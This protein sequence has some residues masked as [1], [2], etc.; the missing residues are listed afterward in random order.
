MGLDDMESA[1]YNLAGLAGQRQFAVAMGLRQDFLAEGMGY[2]WLGCVLPA[3][4]GTWSAD[5]VRHGNT[6]YNEQ[7][8]SVAYALPLS[9]Q[10]SLGAALHYLYSGTSDPYYTPQHLLTFSLAT[11]YRPN[12]RLT[13]GVR[14][15]NPVSM[16]LTSAEEVHTPI[17]FTLGASYRLADELLAVAEVEKQ[18]YHPESMRFGLEY[19]WNRYF[20]ARAGVATQPIIWS[21]GLGMKRSHYAIDIAVQHHAV[22]GITPQLSGHYSF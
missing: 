22:L 8:A 4:T 11:R 7:K 9:G 3:A 16:R 18:L 14:V 5:Y 20:Y 6:E 21:L 2:Q 15:Y 1:I 17:F 12:E 13:V 19:C 10:I